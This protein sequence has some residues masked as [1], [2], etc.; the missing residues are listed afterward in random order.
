MKP[1]LEGVH[2]AESQRRGGF[3]EI[4]VRVSPRFQRLGARAKILDEFMRIADFTIER[5]SRQPSGLLGTIEKSIE[6]TRLEE[7][8]RALGD[9]G[10]N[11]GSRPSDAHAKRLT[12]GFVR[13]DLGR[14]RRDARRSR[15]SRRRRR[16]RRSLGGDTTSRVVVRRRHVHGRN[17][18]RGAIDAREDGG[19]VETRLDVHRDAGALE[20][21]S[22][23]PRHGV[24]R[25]V[26]RSDDVQPALARVRWNVTVRDRALHEIPQRARGD[27]DDLAIRLGVARQRPRFQIRHDERR[28][29]LG[30]LSKRFEQRRSDAA[31]RVAVTVRDERGKIDQVR[32]R[33]AQGVENDV[34]GFSLTVVGATGEEYSTS[35]S[36]VARHEL[37]FLFGGGVV[38][39]ICIITAVRRVRCVRCRRIARPST[40]RHGARVDER[41]LER[42]R[43]RRRARRLHRRQTLGRRRRAAL[44]A[45]HDG[46]SHDAIEH[47]TQKVLQ[48]FTS[49]HERGGG[50]SRRTRARRRR[51]RSRPVARRHGHA[52]GATLSVL[53]RQRSSAFERL[54][55]ALA[56]LGRTFDRIDVVW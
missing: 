56:R 18:T 38:V 41:A 40:R 51:Q 42:R 1:A 50:A 37:F 47:R 4:R 14:R 19:V 25:R 20:K 3:V 46:V 15:R 45:L 55:R 23:R 16:R 26:H 39:V 30:R 22:N 7:F 5:Q 33:S 6:T 28:L 11:Y 10:A 27:A 8:S 36:I 31:R 34:Q 29:R 53:A 17:L 13:V 32:G 12:R 21:V 9:G 35:P 24:P 48:R 54:Q 44:H 52:F 43:V 49:R 2:R